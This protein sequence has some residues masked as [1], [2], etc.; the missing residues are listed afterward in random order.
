MYIFEFNGCVEVYIK[1]C[2]HS[3]NQ[4]R[5]Q[6]ATFCVHPVYRYYTPS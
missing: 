5:S 6:E 1:S 3:G 4:Q 2:T